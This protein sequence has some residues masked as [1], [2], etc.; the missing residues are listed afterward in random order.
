VFNSHP[1]FSLTTMAK[2]K[3][4]PATPAPKAS[5]APSSGSGKK[6]SSSRATAYVLALLFIGAFVGTLQS[7]P[8]QL[9]TVHELLKI[10]KRAETKPF[11]NFAEFYPFYQT[12]HTNSECRLA[13]VV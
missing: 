10:G 3:S 13:H 1:N 12:Q 6:D 9:P 8:Q 4:Q 2:G 7:L 5:K 11:T